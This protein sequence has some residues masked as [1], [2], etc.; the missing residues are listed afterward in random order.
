MTSRTV[1]PKIHST[2]DALPALPTHGSA[3]GFGQQGRFDF[4]LWD[5]VFKL[6]STRI[7]PAR[8]C[9]LG[10]SEWSV[11]ATVQ[12]MRDGDAKSCPAEH[13]D[14]RGRAEQNLSL[15][16]AH[17]RA[18]LPC[19]ELFGALPSDAV[20]TWAELAAR[21]RQARTRAD[22]CGSARTLRQV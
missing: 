20:G 13:R 7:L 9:V 15:S 2:C 8:P 22:T 12:G 21:R 1:G 4:L 17:S 5:S 10:I 11:L 19:Q 16:L 14:L 18:V 3:G 6:R